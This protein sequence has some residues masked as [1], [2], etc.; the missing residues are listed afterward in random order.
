[1]KVRIAGIVK[2]SCV[3]GPGIRLVIFFQGCPHHCDGCHNPDTWD[4]NGGYEIDTDE[5]AKMIK[6][7]KFI[8]G[9]TFSGGE[10]LR[11]PEAIC[12]LSAVAH[13]R[14]LNVWCY[15]GYTIEQ[16][17]N[18]SLLKAIHSV[19]VVVDGQFIKALKETTLLYKGSTNQRI[20]YIK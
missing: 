2:H 20:I 19:N 7:T 12:E 6:E 15:T 8:D 16:I 13:E 4:Y 10:P 3:D 9:V 5:L 18:T 1:M 11:W 17:T 14:G